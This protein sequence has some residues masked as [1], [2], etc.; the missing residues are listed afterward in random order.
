MLDERLR[1]AMALYDPCNLAADIGTDHAR[2]PSALLRSGICKRMIL[3]DISR[4][5]LDNARME[6]RRHHLDSAADLRLGDGLEPI[7][8]RCDMISV[9]GMGGRTIAD[10]LLRG[11]DR[12]QGASLLLSAHT[13]LDRV[14]RAVMN[15]GY[16]LESETP[17][18]DAG[19]FYLLL[20][21]RPGAEKLTEQELRMGVCLF[22]S[23]SPVLL[24][25][26]LH[27]RDILSARLHGLK[28][29]SQ[30]DEALMEE[31]RKDLAYLAEK[32]GTRFIP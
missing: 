22:E 31:T 17:C 25:Y 8:E 21:A 15:L 11:A 1:S 13:D 20:K 9:L 27:R 29:A 10:I 2:L 3:T 7:R 4:S 28:Q 12:L 26:L 5:A 6:I 14:R 18:L 23:D 16:H 24:P 19:R 30:P 32:T